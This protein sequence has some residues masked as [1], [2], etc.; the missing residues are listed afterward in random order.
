MWLAD[1]GEGGGTCREGS[2]DGK[3]VHEC[4][5]VQVFLSIC[6]SFSD[7]PKDLGKLESLGSVECFFITFLQLSEIEV[8]IGVK[9][10]VLVVLV[11]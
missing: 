8:A 6:F 10:S 5:T 11:T 3:A 1:C 4:I 2:D 7:C 9:E